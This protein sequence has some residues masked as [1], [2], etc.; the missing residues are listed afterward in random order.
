VAAPG[1]RP[2]TTTCPVGPAT[3]PRGA[4]HP[5]PVGAAATCSSRAGFKPAARGCTAT[6]PATRSG[7]GS[8][9]PGWVTPQFGWRHEGG[10][11]AAGGTWTARPEG[12]H[13][14]NTKIWP[15]CLSAAGLGL[16]LH[17]R[18]RGTTGHA[19]FGTWLEIARQ[20]VHVGDGRAVRSSGWRSTTTRSSTTC[21]APAHGGPAVALYVLPR[22]EALAHTL[23][24]TAST[25]SAG[26]TRPSRCAPCRPPLPM[27]GPGA[28]REL[29]DE[30]T[31]A[32]L[33]QFGEDH[34][35]AC[36]L[37]RGRR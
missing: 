24:R 25:A 17:D 26:A 23:Y 36:I 1:P 30:I 11:C 9:S 7:T 21:T 13:C 12:P 10:Q 16:L 4:W 27:P 35:G 20:A 18:L 14:E 22:D 2:V 3:L 31:H 8:W 28:G 29:G 15:Y 37:R 33:A 19:V 32:R 6:C 34:F 5:D